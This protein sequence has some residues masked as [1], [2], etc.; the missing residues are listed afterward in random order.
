MDRKTRVMQFADEAY[1]LTVIGRNV[2]V[3]DPMKEYVKEKISKIE[4]FSQRII[5]INVTMDV[6]KLE[7]RVDIVMKLDNIKIKSH[8]STEDMY[9]SIDE[10]VDK[11]VNQLR[12]YKT[13]IQDHHAK[14]VKAIDMNVNVIRPYTTDEVV[15]INEEIEEESQRRLVEQYQPHQIVS[16]ETL[17]LKMLSYDEAVMKMELSKNAFLI[18]KAEH[19]GKLKVIYRRNDNNYG[20]IELEK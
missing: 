11:L 15:S 9:A 3:T 13:K 8:A 17:P 7:H 12:R 16:R 5:E 1:N 2:L 20:I 4:R 18:F 14:G 6:Q 10:A 19:D